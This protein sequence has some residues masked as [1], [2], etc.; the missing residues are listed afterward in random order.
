MPVAPEWFAHE[1]LPD[2]GQRVRWTR[3]HHKACGEG[4]VTLV[5]YGVEVCIDIRD[6]SGAMQHIYQS[7]GDTWEPA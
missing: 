5:W 4:I 6:D 3:Q 2:K 7:L 1:T